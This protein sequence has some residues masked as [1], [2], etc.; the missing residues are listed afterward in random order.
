M[1]I[2][3][4]DEKVPAR[5]NKKTYEKRVPPIIP[6]PRTLSNARRKKSPAANISKARSKGRFASPIRIK[7]R[8]LGIRYSTADKNRQ[9]LP[10]IASVLY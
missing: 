4:A 10:R 3:A 8:G 9:R 5:E 7:G 2:N 6:C 1:D